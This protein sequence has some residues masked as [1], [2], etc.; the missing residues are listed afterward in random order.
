MNAAYRSISGIGR[1]KRSASSD[2]MPE[3]RQM[4]NDNTLSR[5]NFDFNHILQSQK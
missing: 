2:Q 3:V 4:V 5:S 1:E